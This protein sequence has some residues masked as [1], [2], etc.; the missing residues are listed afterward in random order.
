MGKRSSTVSTASTVA[1]SELSARKYVQVPHWGNF[2]KNHTRIGESTTKK[3]NDQVHKLYW[4]VHFQATLNLVAGSKH[5]LKFKRQFDKAKENSRRQAEM[6]LTRFRAT[7]GLED[8]L[9]LRG[10]VARPRLNLPRR[11]KRRADGKY[12]GRYSFPAAWLDADEVEQEE[13]DQEDEEE[14]NDDE[15]EEPGVIHG[16]EFLTPPRDTP[17]GARADLDR[18]DSVRGAKDKF[19]ELHYDIRD[20]VRRKKLAR[21]CAYP[22][23]KMPLLEGIHVTSKDK[24]GVKA[25]AYACQV[26]C[27][28]GPQRAVVKGDYKTARRLAEAD[29]TD[30]IKSGRTFAEMKGILDR[31]VDTSIDQSKSECGE[32]HIHKIS[33][34]FFVRLPLMDFVTIHRDNLAD[35]VADRNDIK[36]ALNDWKKARK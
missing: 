22:Q 17:E 10:A 25:Y 2:V 24:D 32:H 11:V 35:A 36:Q 30:M 1:K 16:K 29:L 5:K 14:E 15:K 4:D 3:A 26:L 7:K 31:R 21:K 28:H 34:K 33:S 12:H 6:M 23:D 19:M 20:E 9:R 27:V 8:L 13:V 18:L